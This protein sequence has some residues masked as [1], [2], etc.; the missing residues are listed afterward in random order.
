MSRREIAIFLFYLC[1]ATFGFGEFYRL[2][3]AIRAILPLDNGSIAHLFVVYG[4]HGSSEDNHKL[5]LTNKLLEA[6]ICEVR[7]C[8]TRQPVIITGDLDVE[9]SVILVTAKA[10]QCGYF[11]D[12]EE[13]CSGGRGEHP[14]PTCMQV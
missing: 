13:A 12:L 10:L 8:G 7:V 2:G 5:A 1:D 9:P 14:F 11:V 4:Y 6:V 3:R